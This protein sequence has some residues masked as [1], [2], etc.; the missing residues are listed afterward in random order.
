M[1]VDPLLKTERA[2]LRFEAIG[3]DKVGVNASARQTP[4]VRRHAG[5]GSPESILQPVRRGFEGHMP[6]DE[7]ASPQCVKTPGSLCSDT[8]LRL[9]ARVTRTEGTVSSA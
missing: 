5:V 3:G 4:A 6:A 2:T 8:R 7:A 9:V 1:S